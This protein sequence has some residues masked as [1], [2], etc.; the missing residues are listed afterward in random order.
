MVK[1]AIPEE[2]RPANMASDQVEAERSTDGSG[3]EPEKSDDSSEE[4]ED[5][6]PVYQMMTTMFHVG[7]DKE[8]DETAHVTMYVE[9]R[10]GNNLLGTGSDPTDY[11]RTV[12]IFLSR[13]RSRCSGANA[14]YVEAVGLAKAPR[15]RDKWFRIDGAV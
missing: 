12:M 3:T 13:L 5:D 8:E 11:G 1:V 2:S 15:P 7:N 6:I 4:S 14:D 9:V 10:K